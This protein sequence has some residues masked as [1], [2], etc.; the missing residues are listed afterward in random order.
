MTNNRHDD[1]DP[2]LEQDLKDSLKDQ[3]VLPDVEIPQHVDRAV[4]AMATT[5]ATQIRHELHRSQRSHIFKYAAAAAAVLIISLTFMAPRHDTRDGSLSVPV[6]KQQV[7]L[8]QCDIV[9][10]YL[11]ACRLASGEQLSR[12][13]DHNKDSHVDTADVDQIA[14]MAVSLT[15]MREEEGPQDA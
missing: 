7:V 13:D 9:D 10:A 14:K 1:I 11:L 8:E 6:A 15:P 5:K 2:Q 3:S 4:L 12:E